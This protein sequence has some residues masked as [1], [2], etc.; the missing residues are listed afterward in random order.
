MVQILPYQPPCLRRSRAF[1][2]TETLIVV[3]LVSIVMAL[4]VPSTQSMLQK[5]RAAQC[6]ANLRQI[7]AAMALYQADNNNSLPK[8][9]DTASGYYWFHQLLGFTA[10]GQGANY[11][12]SAKVL[13]CPSNP[14]KTATF[15][16]TPPTVVGFGM[17]DPIIWTPSTHR[18]QDEARLPM[19]IVKLSDWPL[20]MDA[21]KLAI[22]SLD[23][24]TAA[25][26]GDSRY[27][28]RHNNRANV[29]MADGH[30]EQAA[31]GEKRWTQSVLN[32][33]A[34]LGR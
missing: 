17:Y 25:A 9:Y 30:I 13:A 14:K 28:A 5:G 34:Y 7:G 31:Y 21:D 2:L 22:Y 26:A 11:L 20:V 18:S 27:A 24:P 15:L 29:L 10:G 23:N 3:A 6:Q 16:T 12:G 33:P 8:V 4:I 19:K 32:S 1:S